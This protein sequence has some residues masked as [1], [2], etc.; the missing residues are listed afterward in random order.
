MQLPDIGGVQEQI[1]F[2][3]GA[4]P[5]GHI[6]EQ[7]YFDGERYESILSQGATQNLQA[8]QGIYENQQKD[9]VEMNSGAHVV[10]TSKNLLLGQDQFEMDLQKNGYQIAAAPGGGAHKL[11]EFNRSGAKQENFIK[12]GKQNF[13]EINKNLMQQ[14][15]PA[16]Q[17]QRKPFGHQV[18]HA[19]K[20]DMAEDEPINDD[21]MAMEMSAAIGNPNINRLMGQ[22]IRGIPQLPPT[23]GSNLSGYEVKASKRGK[24][25]PLL[26]GIFLGEQNEKSQT[27]NIAELLQQVNKKSKST[28]HQNMLLPGAGLQ[29]CYGLASGTYAGEGST[30]ARQPPAQQLAQRPPADG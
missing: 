21:F 17:Q 3:G 8:N 13:K 6:A 30:V 25:N 22:D 10:N 16:E 27:G 18:Y 9:I 11:K 15:D 19:N 4:A 29:P 5:Q 24:K 23:S 20:S 2:Y 1:D 12:T 28:K 7:E 26:G 14:P